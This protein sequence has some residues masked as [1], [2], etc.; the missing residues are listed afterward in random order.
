MQDT[1]VRPE[2]SAKRITRKNLV[3]SLLIGLG[4]GILAGAPL[5]WF[6]HRIYA[7]QRA[8]QVLLCRQQSFGVSEAELQSRCGSVY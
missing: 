8:A 3:S 5:G 1:T 7:Q 6:T 2:R 4:L